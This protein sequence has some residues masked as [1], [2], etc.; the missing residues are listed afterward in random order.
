MAFKFGIYGE[1]SSQHKKVARKLRK[2]KQRSQKTHNQKADPEAVESTTLRGDPKPKSPFS[3]N[4]SPS[5]SIVWK[6]RRL[7]LSC[8]AKVKCCLAKVKCC[9]A[10]V[11]CPLAKTKCRLAKVKCCLAKVKVHSAKVIKNAV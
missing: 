11:K 9:L 1:T 7:T 3:S 2:A 6:P 8:L 10:K 4:T 5:S